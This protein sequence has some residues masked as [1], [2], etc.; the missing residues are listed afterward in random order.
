MLMIGMLF[1]TISCKTNKQLAKENLL[2]KMVLDYET[3]YNQ[4]AVEKAIEII[5]KDNPFGMSDTSFV[6]SPHYFIGNLNAD[7]I[8]KICAVD[9]TDNCTE[10]YSEANKAGRKTYT[11]LVFSHNWELNYFP[12]LNPPKERTAKNKKDGECILAILNRPIGNILVFNVYPYSQ[13]VVDVMGKNEDSLFA[14]M[15]LKNYVYEFLF[16]EET[17][18]L[19]LL[20]KGAIIH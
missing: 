10:K 7:E 4:I 17:S 20:S 11:E 3:A 6:I 15:G 14:R 2:S 16:F 18:E 19:I 13:E 5:V 8:N 9:K 12:L 1:F